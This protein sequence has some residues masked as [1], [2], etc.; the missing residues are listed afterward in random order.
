[1]K[2]VPS[3]HDSPSGGFLVIPEQYPNEEDHRDVP[4]PHHRIFASEKEQDQDGG[5]SRGSEEHRAISESPR[6]QTESDKDFYQRYDEDQERRNP[7]DDRLPEAGQESG[8]V[9]PGLTDKC[10]V[11]FLKAGPKISSGDD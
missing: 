6:E 11:Q 5:V 2:R 3:R 10:D 9:R 4:R 1:M 7:L 8:H